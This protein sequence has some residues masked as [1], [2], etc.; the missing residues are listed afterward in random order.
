MIS[1]AAWIIIALVVIAYGAL[2][3]LDRKQYQKRMTEAKYRKL[4]V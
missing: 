1:V 3:I 4:P 2:H